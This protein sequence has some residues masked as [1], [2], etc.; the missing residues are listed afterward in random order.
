MLQK[1]IYEYNVYNNVIVYLKLVV[2]G[3]KSSNIFYY[4]K[5]LKC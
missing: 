5:W 1:I 3:L 2:K 4:M